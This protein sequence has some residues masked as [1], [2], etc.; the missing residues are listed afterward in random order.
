MDSLQ[1]LL[2]SLF[3][4]DVSFF[5]SLWDI[6]QGFILF[7][8][9]VVAMIYRSRDTVSRAIARVKTTE[10][11]KLSGELNGLKVG[12]HS[13]VNEIKEVVTYMA[14]MMVTMSLASPVL[15]DKAKQKIA[16]YAEQISCIERTAPREHLERIETELDKHGGEVSRYAVPCYTFSTLVK[17]KD[18]T[19]LS[20]DAESHELY[21]L[22]GIDFSY[23]NIKYISFEKNPYDKNDCGKFLESMGYSQVNT[24][25]VDHFYKKRHYQGRILP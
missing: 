6:I 16:G 14:D 7:G 23:H 22:Q 1:E 17:E 13:E 11:E 2:A 10:V 19:Y 3:G 9:G 15:L 8:G 12:V 25:G 21:I 24:I 20:I 18:I 5:S 4:G